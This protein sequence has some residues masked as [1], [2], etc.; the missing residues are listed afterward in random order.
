MN[1]PA[2]D[3]SK[4]QKVMK[5]MLFVEWEESSDVLGNTGLKRPDTFK[6]NHHTGIVVKAGPWVEPEILALLKKSERKKNPGPR[7]RILFDRFSGVEGYR[8]PN[9]GKRYAFIRESTQGA[10]YAIIPPRPDG[11]PVKIS[12]VEGDVNYDL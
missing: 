4:V 3:A 8:D 10:A 6:L 7:P 2:I 5:D 11:T 9:T 12:G 1:Y